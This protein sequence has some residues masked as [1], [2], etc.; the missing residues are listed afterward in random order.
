MMTPA[1]TKYTDNFV[2]TQAR[3]KWREVI[4]CLAASGCHASI[5]QAL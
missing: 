4:K 1:M 3:L 5:N 2:N